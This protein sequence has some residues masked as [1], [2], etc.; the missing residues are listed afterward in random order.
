MSAL[1]GRC[2]CSLSLSLSL[3]L[4]FS[5][6]LAFLALPAIGLRGHERVQLEMDVTPPGAD[7]R[8][9]RPKPRSLARENSHLHHSTTPPLHHCDQPLLLRS[10]AINSVQFSPIRSNPIQFNSF[11]PWNHVRISRPLIPRGVRAGQ[12]DW[13]ALESWPISSPSV[14]GIRPLGRDHDTSLACRHN[15]TRSLGLNLRRVAILPGRPMP[16]FPHVFRQ[17]PTNT[18]PCAHNHDIHPSTRPPQTKTAASAV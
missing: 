12:S 17:S 11:A 8:T 1:R 10:S 13:W 9:P 6:R 3:S 15:H 7:E 4:S 5:L 16:R 14:S 2:V 18:A